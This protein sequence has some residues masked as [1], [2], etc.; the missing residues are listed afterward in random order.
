[1]DKVAYL[2]ADIKYCDQFPQGDSVAFMD[3]SDGGDYTAISCV[4]GYLQGVAAHGHVWKKAWY[5]CLDDLVLIIKQRGVKKLFFET[6]AT[7]TQPIVQLR[8]LL[9]PMGVSVEGTHSDSNK[10]A[11][12]SAAGSVCGSI[13]LSR[14]SDKL[15]TDMV[16]KYELKSKFDDA[17]DSLA[18]CL[19]RLGLLRGKR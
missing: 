13:H 12:I 4:K 15:Y 2:F 14:E 9:A 7:G 19:E 3:P 8:A 11:I 16:V 17:P 5:H 6:N 10:H 18:R 1:M